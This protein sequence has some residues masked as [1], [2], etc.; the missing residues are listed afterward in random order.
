MVVWWLQN[1]WKTCWF[2][3]RTA[4]AAPALVAPPVSQHVDV[5]ST[6]NT[7]HDR[8]VPL[9]SASPSSPCSPAA[10]DQYRCTHLFG[11]R[12]ISLDLRHRSEPYQFKFDA[13]LPEETTQ[14]EVFERE[15]QRCDVSWQGG[16]G[17]VGGHHL[18]EAAAVKHWERC[19]VCQQPVNR[20]CMGHESA[21]AHKAPY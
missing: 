2:A 1:S 14:E 7:A 4:A 15:Q 18:V 8:C 11:E 16:T 5:T 9:C 10:A 12:G 17:G 13:I 3:R 21:A 20:S 6:P 19:R